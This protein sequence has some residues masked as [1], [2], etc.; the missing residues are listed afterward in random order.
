MSL[1]NTPRPSAARSAETSPNIAAEVTLST[2]SA[3]I[4]SISD[5]YRIL[6]ADSAKH[7][8]PVIPGG[9]MEAADVQSDAA[10]PGLTC[11][12]REVIEEIGTALLN[13]R[14]IGKAVDPDRDIRLVPAEKLINAVVTPALPESIAPDATVKAHYGCPDYIFTGQVDEAAIS[15]TEELKRVRFVDIRTLGAGDLSAGHDVIVAA[16]RQ[17]LDD[18]LSAL[19]QGA[20][21]NFLLEREKLATGTH[22]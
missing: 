13:P 15:S 7:S 1:G 21:T 14:C 18:G 11:V 2:A 3:I 17:M 10:T 19:P 20:L 22:R 5:L 16:Y 6:V 12:L 4:A 8:R 9:K